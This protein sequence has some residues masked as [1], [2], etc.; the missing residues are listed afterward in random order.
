[1]HTDNPARR[2]LKILENGKK[3]STATSC[4]KVWCELLRV[5][6]S[7]RAL[8]MS[9]LGKVM[10][11]PAQIIEKIR[12]NYPNQGSSH[13][14]WSNK[15]NTAFMQQNLN[16]K[17]EGFISHIDNHTISYLKIAVDLLD[18]KDMT[19]IMED[20]ELADI[21]NKVDDL[22]QEAIDAE[23]DPGFKKY[24]VRYLRKII[25]SIDEYHISGAV[26]IAE[27]IECTIG[28][29]HLDENYRK[30]I[31]G[32]EL[33]RKLIGI[34][35]TVASVVTLAI[36][37]PQFPQLPEAFQSLLESNEQAS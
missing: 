23:I 34:L 35:H 2:L 16:G 17:W 19:E 7:D 24:I 1:M 27:S 28:H 15:V 6:G 29:V 37:L 30:N 11:L 10:E 32:S 13:Q 26:P 36:G 12:E 14:H 25:A 18:M 21:R 5:D 8:L 31:L 4:S 3:H 20:D 22:L 9:R 33:G